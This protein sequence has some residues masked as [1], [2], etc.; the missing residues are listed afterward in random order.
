MPT[1]ARS[2]SHVEL[3]K[4]VEASYAMIDR[5][6]R[7]NLN[8]TL[9]QG[10]PARHDDPDADRTFV[11]EPLKVLQI[12]IKERV[13]VVPFDFQ[14]DGAVVGSSHMIDFMRDRGPLDIVDSLPDNDISLDPLPLREGASEP[15]RRIGFPASTL[16]QLHI[17]DPKIQQG[18]AQLSKRFGKILG[19]DRQR[20]ILGLDVET[21][22]FEI[23]QAQ[24]EAVAEL[25]L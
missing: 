3:F 5:A 17:C 24:G 2:R 21:C 23:G 16:D 20:V 11:V 15:L 7:D 6:R 12:A 19:K 14:S 18:V 13:L 10:L 22:P 9:L 1:L 8:H 4:V 25:L